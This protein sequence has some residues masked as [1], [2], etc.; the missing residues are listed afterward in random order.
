MEILKYTEDNNL[1]DKGVY[2]ISHKETSLIYI[3]STFQKTGF[4]GRWRQ[5]LLAI[6][7]GNGN[8]VLHRIYKKYGIEGFKFTILERMNNSTEAEIRE[9]EAYYINKYNSYYKGANMSLSTD[10]SFRIMKHFP[11]TPE[12]CQKYKDTCTTKKPM[13]VYNGEGELMYTFESGVEADRFFNLKKGASADKAK[14]CWSYHNQYWFS[15]EIRDWKPRQIKNENMKK[16]QE[17]THETRLKNNS[18]NP[19]RPKKGYHI[20]EEQKVKERLSN[21]TRLQVDLYNLD[22]SFFMHFNSLN[23]CDDFLGLTR[24]TTSKVLMHKNGAK[25]LRRKY[26][27]IKHTNTVLTKQI[28]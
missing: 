22:G 2:M 26:I 14:K 7:K 28:A 21:P 15:R 23:E 11:N 3:G 24:G 16:A 17:A 27:P 4:E 18:Y 8:I 9:K 12:M 25:T 10:C 19:P 13:Y 1:R 5:H 6:K 20:S